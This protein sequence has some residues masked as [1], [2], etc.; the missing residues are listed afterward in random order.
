MKGISVLKR[1][2]LGKYEQLPMLLLLAPFFIFFFVFQ[3][4]KIRLISKRIKV[5]H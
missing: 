3:K 4:R 1:S 2:R 5:Y